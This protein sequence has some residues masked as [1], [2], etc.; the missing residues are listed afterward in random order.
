MEATLANRG[1]FWRFW[2]AYRKPLGLDPYLEKVNFQ[3]KTRVTTGF[4]GRKQKGSHVRGKQIQ[5]GTVREAIGGDNAKIYLDT[6]RKPLHQPVPNDKYIL[7][8]QYIIKGFENKDP[9]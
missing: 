3:T 8:L 2:R 9:P 1:K 4:E 5:V 7:P 6:W